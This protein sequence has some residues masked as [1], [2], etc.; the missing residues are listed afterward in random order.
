M[1]QD[2]TKQVKKVLWFILFANLFVAVTKIAI[3]NLIQSASMSADGFHSLTDGV[4]NVVGLIGIGYAAKPVDDDHPYGHKKYECL[5]G[6]FIGGMLVVIAAQIMLEAFSRILQPVTPQFGLESIAALL[7]TLLINIIVC[8]YEY[9]QGKRLN[10]YILISDSLHTRSDI[11]VSLGVLTTLVCIKL[12]APP[13]VDPIASMVVGG[14]IV[15]AAIEIIKSTSNI[16]VD[17]VAI[18]LALIKT[19]TL[20]F[21]QVMDVHEIRSRGSESDPFVDMHIEI[22]PVMSIEAAH[23]LVHEIEEKL[24]NEINPNL[25]VLIHTEPYA[26]ASS[27]NIG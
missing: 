27:G 20:S 19:I 7:L 17:R 21:S 13:L 22:D 5:T 16:L 10:S 1:S 24:K 15:H 4:S 26:N 23:D 9:R 6:L 2:T 8:V 11:F 14:F 25:Q 12:G 18:D 3:G